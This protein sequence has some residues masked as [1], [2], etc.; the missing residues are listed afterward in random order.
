[1]PDGKP[2]AFRDERHGPGQTEE[3][4]HANNGT[5]RFKEIGGIQLVIFLHV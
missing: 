2:V 1:M 3:R 4:E 5:R